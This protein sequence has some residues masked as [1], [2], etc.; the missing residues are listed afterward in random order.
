MDFSSNLITPVVF[1]G[2][3]DL[4]HEGEEGTERPKPFQSRSGN[5][6]LFQQTLLRVTDPGRFNPPIIIADQA[7]KSLVDFQMEMIGAERSAVLLEPLSGGTAASLALAAL[8]SGAFGSDGAL[9]A[10]PGD[11]RVR[12]PNAWLGAVEQAI[13]GAHK[14]ALLAFGRK[15]SAGD[16]AQAWIQRGAHLFD[17]AGGGVVDAE[18]YRMGQFLPADTDKDLEALS[19][20]GDCYCNSGMYLFPVKS[21]LEDLLQH[22]P[23]VLTACQQALVAGS[24]EGDV[25]TP[26]KEKL[27]QC[28]VLSIEAALFERTSRGALVPTGPLWTEEAAKPSAEDDERPEAETPR[29]EDNVVLRDVSNSEILTRGPLTV[30]AGLSDVIVV[31]TGESVV[32]AARSHVSALL[33]AVGSDGAPVLSETALRMLCEAVRSDEES[34]PADPTEEPVLDTSANQAAAEEELAFEPEINPGTLEDALD[35]LFKGG[36]QEDGEVVEPE[37]LLQAA[38][39]S[40]A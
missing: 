37:L 34:E 33:D 24:T 2:G 27:S 35:E 20:E 8:V 6:S 1:C 30:V 22:A 14:G 9:L 10:L 25:L 29:S 38:M 3:M 13:T 36:E 19:E 18:V 4:H 26:N 40:A 31:N 16:E 15:A 7:H 39:D 17:E 23:A 11:Q 5:L 32:V 12:D 28:P 21:V